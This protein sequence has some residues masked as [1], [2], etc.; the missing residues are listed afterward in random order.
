MPA[1]DE[2]NS[3]SV[4]VEQLSGC[5]ERSEQSMQRLQQD[6]VAAAQVGVMVGIPAGAALHQRQLLRCAS[7]PPRSS[8][9]MAGSPHVPHTRSA[10]QQ[11]RLGSRRQ[12]SRVGGSRLSWSELALSSRKPRR[13]APRAGSLQSDCWQGGLRGKCRWARS[14]ATSSKVR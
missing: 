11:Q 12:R 7:D 4:Q 14:L 3:P 6:L 1:A 13:C 10:A 9:P 8:I 2:G 5:L